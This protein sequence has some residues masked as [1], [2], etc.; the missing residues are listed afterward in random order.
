MRTRQNPLFY[1]ITKARKNYR[2]CRKWRDGG[3][4][5]G[6]KRDVRKRRW[7][8]GTFT[9]SSSQTAPAD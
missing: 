8:A 6:L 7:R 5:G 2:K 4:G 1:G 9:F 3:G